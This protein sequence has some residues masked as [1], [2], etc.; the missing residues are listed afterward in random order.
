MCWLINMDFS[1]EI[2]H[3]PST[4]NIKGTDVYDATHGINL[5]HTEQKL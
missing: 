3:S 1:M 4:F 2:R 5:Q